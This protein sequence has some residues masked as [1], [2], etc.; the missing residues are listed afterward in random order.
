MTKNKLKFKNVVDLPV[1]IT[2]WI[3]SNSSI[4][5]HSIFFIGIFALRIFHYTTNDILLILTTAVS[6]EAIYLAIFIQMTVNR[7]TQSL[8]EVE[9]DIEE[10]TGG[11]TDME[12]DIDSIQED[13]DKLED[14]DAKDHVHSS[15]TIS[16]LNKIENDLQNLIDEISKLKKP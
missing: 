12:K 4:V 13:I 15:N 11:V 5:F 2:D 6:L 10:I 1:K 9:E 14:E 8:E 3:G 16:T 7:N